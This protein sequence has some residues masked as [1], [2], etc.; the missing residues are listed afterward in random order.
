MSQNQATYNDIISLQET[1][2][3]LPHL[4]DGILD[5]G[6]G[7]GRNPY[8]LCNRLLYTQSRPVSFEELRSLFTD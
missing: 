4:L 3:F 5:C 7:I 8:Y 2:G 1:W 6:R